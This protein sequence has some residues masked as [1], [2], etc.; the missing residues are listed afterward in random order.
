[1]T[2][3]QGA[4]LHYIDNENGIKD[5]DVWSFYRAAP[6]RPYPYRRRGVMDFGD[7]K[8]GQTDDSLSFKGRRVDLL[9]RSLEVSDGCDPVAA[10]R[11]YLA[12]GRTQSARLL[13]QK[14]VVLIEPGNELGTVIWP[15]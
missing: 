1:M 2:L 12:G 7:P 9:G 3:C 11:D 5:F 14:A 13:A 8:F 10:L 15:A 6:E 4:A